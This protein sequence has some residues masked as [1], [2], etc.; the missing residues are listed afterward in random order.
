MPQEA[1]VI[2][3]ST[4]FPGRVLGSHELVDAVAKEA[5]GDAAELEVGASSAQPMRRMDARLQRSTPGGAIRRMKTSI[6]S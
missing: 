6:V 5:A 1:G 4:I 2:T 3:F